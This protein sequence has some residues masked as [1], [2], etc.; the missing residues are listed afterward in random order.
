[1]I[2][3]RITQKHQATIPAIIRKALDLHEGDRVGFE[4]HD[5]EIII[6]KVTPLDLEFAKA[7]EGTVT[8]WASEEDD[9]LYANL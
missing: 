4:I 7:L 2:S 3:S 9:K 8:E 6:R 5:K 1:M